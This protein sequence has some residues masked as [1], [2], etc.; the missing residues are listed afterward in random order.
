[1]QVQSLRRQG[2]NWQVLDAQ[3][4]LLAEAPY[5]VVCAG[6]GSH[7]LLPHALPLQALRGQLSWGWR[8]AG[9]DDAFPD[10]PVNG[11][12][13]FIPQVPTDL[14]LAWYLGS[15]FERDSTDTRSRD[16][17][18]S[19]NYAKLQTLLPGTAQALERAFDQNQ[20]QSFTAVRC[21]TP[22]R[23][24]VV[25]PL[26]ALNL[27]GLWLSTAMGASGMASPGPWKRNWRRH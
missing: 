24:P 20:L 1:M 8:N 17:D 12:G 4:R 23:L 26:D 21:T 25:G 11:N 18:H 27:P 10:T 2:E 22:D 19:S 6:F 3:G 16:S 9:D 13:N 15:S 14:G 5:I 7:A